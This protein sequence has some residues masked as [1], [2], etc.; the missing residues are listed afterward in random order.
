MHVVC[1]NVAIIASGVV[2]PA[3]LIEIHVHMAGAFGLFTEN[4]GVA[5]ERN[6]GELHPVGVTP[7]HDQI[8]ILRREGFLPKIIEA[9]DQVAAILQKTVA[10]AFEN[11]GILIVGQ[12][13]VSPGVAVAT[14]TSRQFVVMVARIHRGGD[15]ELADVVEALRGIRL[16]LG[17]GE[18]REKHGGKNADDADYNEHLYERERVRAN[19]R[20][21][22]LRRG[23]VFSGEVVGQ[24]HASID[25]TALGPFLLQKSA[26]H[27]GQLWNK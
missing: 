2:I 16:G 7:L 9:I 17:P 27:C 8:I 18:R 12:K 19:P 24:S 15:A 21:R 14:S 22:S 13:C 25:K 6:G 23:G 4:D 10:W 20:G 26:R 11:F 5:G 1:D 3:F